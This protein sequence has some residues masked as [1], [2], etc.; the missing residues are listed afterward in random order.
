MISL[1]KNKRKPRIKIELIKQQTTF[2]DGTK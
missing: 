1:R 2:E